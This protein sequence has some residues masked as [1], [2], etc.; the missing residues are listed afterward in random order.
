MDVP[1]RRDQMRIVGDQSRM[2]AA[3]EQRP[4]T[5]ETVVDVS[6]VHR[7]DPLHR[8]RESPAR[9][10]TQ[11]MKVVVEEAVRVDLNAEA[12]VDVGQSLAEFDSIGVIEEH[13]AV[14]D[15][16]VHH[17]VPSVLDVDA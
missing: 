1:D 8:R 11:Q 14:I 5:T 16:T 12:L 2:E 10:S 3:P 7:A 17:V 9:A 13:V 4:V 6:R 15:A